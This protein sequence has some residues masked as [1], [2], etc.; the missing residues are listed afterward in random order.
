[1]EQSE[2]WDH[3]QDRYHGEPFLVV[4]Q[5]LALRYP[6]K[7]TTALDI[8]VGSVVSERRP[9][10]VGDSKFKPAVGARKP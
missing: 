5:R 3:W 9:G 1:M 7:G 6:L 8:D 2:I 4:S 10:A